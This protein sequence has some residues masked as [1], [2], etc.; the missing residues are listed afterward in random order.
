MYSYAVR[1]CNDRPQPIAI[2][3]GVW[4][5]PPQTN[6]C[7]GVCSSCTTDRKKRGGGPLKPLIVP[8]PETLIPTGDALRHARPPCTMRL[9]IHDPLIFRQPPTAV[10]TT[11]FSVMEFFFHTIPI[12]H[13]HISLFM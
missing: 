3:I 10:V 2:R 5:D 4:G 11:L 9:R 13:T 12:S 6:V 8:A 1:L 7:A